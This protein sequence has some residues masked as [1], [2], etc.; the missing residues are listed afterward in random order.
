V[1]EVGDGR[2][3]ATRDCCVEQVASVAVHVVV[4]AIARVI[5]VAL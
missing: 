2:E 3:A 1:H 4:D 5:R